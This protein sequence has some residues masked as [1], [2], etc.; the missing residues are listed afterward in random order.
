[1]LISLIINIVAIINVFIIFVL[2]F[3]RRENALPNKVLAVAFL[4]PGLYFVNNIFIIHGVEKYIPFS[5]F[6]VQ[7]IAVGFPI[8][9]YYYFNLLVGRSLCATKDNWMIVSNLDQSQ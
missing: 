6:F 5:L 4:I 9:I 7:A 8:M 3:F 1:M 2:L